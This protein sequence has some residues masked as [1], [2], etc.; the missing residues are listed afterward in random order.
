MFPVSVE[1]VLV[2]QR[3]LG[4]MW[5]AEDSA[6]QCSLPCFLLQ[7]VYDMQYFDCIWY[8][9]RTFEFQYLNTSI[10]ADV[11]VLAGM[12]LTESVIQEI[13]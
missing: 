8:V 4:V 7:S 11:P 9:T 1:L 10:C 2:L 12:N 13:I 5:C 3:C 6:L